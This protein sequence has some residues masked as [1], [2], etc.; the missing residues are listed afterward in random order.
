MKVLVDATIWSY[1]LRK[2]Y[3]PENAAIASE[4]A[5]LVNDGRVA[6]IG[7]I[8]QEVLSGIREHAHFSRL[9]DRMRGFPDTEI[10]FDDYEEA[11]AFYNECQ[12]HGIQGS[13]IDFLI[14][15][16]AVRQGFSIFTT[17]GDFAHYAKVLPITLYGSS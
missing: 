5:S 13:H 6:I 9:R 10:T 16:V 4:L 8:R 2:K 11:A 3:R 1:V 15:A 12:R 14:C 17:D 7:P